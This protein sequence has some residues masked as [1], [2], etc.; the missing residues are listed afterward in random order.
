ML[1]KYNVINLQVQLA[2]YLRSSSLLSVCYRAE[3]FY[4]W[5]WCAGALVR[6][7]VVSWLQSVL[8]RVQY[9]HWCY[10]Y[11][12]TQQAGIP[13]VEICGKSVGVVVR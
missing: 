4:F 12:Y 13:D 7:L 3:L 1:E 6:L 10:S 5:C 9:L 8:L 2:L 11:S